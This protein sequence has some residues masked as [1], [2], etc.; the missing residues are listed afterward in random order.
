MQFTV[1]ALVF[2]FSMA[3]VSAQEAAST[4]VPDNQIL[5]TTKD[6]FPLTGQYFPGKKKADG[7][8]V[9]HDCKSDSRPYHD[10][11]KRISQAGF[12]A[13]A[14]DLRGFGNSVTP[15]VSHQNIKK[16]AKD[17]IAYQQQLAM[18]SAYWE[19]DVL[20]AYDYLRDKV[21][22]QF[23]ISIF[24][25]GCSAPFAVSTA[26]QMHVANMVL[27][28][29]EMDFIAKERYKNLTDIPSYFIS[30]IHNIE[31]YQTSKELF[32]W[33]GHKRSKM[34]LFKGE[35]TDSQLLKR[36]P[37]LS[38]DIASWLIERGKQQ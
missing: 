15:M 29:P 37:S 24:A 35:H 2:L 32:E 12:H 19:L 4:K 10:I 17:I 7:F 27:L 18:I 8:L 30:P 9:L 14:L 34:L 28:S 22:N 1:I 20:N 26:E 23:A 31:S 3:S 33:N 6:K 38:A 25:V 11:A 21:D 36:N 16:N 5:I 13:L